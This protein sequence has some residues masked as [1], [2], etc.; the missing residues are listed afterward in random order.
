MA[1]NSPQSLTYCAR[2]EEK[3]ALPMLPHSLTRPGFVRD[4]MA[5][6]P[7]AQESH[8]YQLLQEYFHF[9]EK[10]MFFNVARLGFLKYLR[11]NTFLDTNRIKILAPLNGATSEW[12]NDIGIDS[13]R[14]Y[15]TPIVNLFSALTDPIPLTEK[16]V[17]YH[18]SQNA[19]KDRT[20]EVY[21]IEQVFA[22]SGQSSEPQEVPPYFSFK[23]S[24][25]PG[26][27]T[28]FLW[29]S[30]NTPTHHKNIYG[31]DTEISFVDADFNIADTSEYIIYTK[32]MCSNRFLAEDILQNTKLQIEMALPVTGITCLKA[33]VTPEYSLKKG[34]NNAKLIAQLSINYLGFPYHHTGDIAE[35]I[36]KIL[37]MHASDQAQPLVSS[38]L[39]EMLAMQVS[40]TT[41][42]V[43]REAWRG[44]VDGVHVQIS[45]KKTNSVESWFLLAVVLQRYFAMNCQINTFVE[46]SLVVDGV[47]AFRLDAV[48]GEQMFI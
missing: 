5:I 4:E 42:R 37:A 38:M 18:V 27:S 28:K 16:R 14:L 31:I 3:V 35:N 10:F 8:A 6:T 47:E 7:K 40:H 23:S 32:A 44:I 21:D 19:Y 36:R 2:G 1:L 12:A 33:P 30:K 13:L 15:C 24:Q 48:S 17:F 43:G 22:L 46:L 34:R 26:N 41:K 20:T 11:E 39:Q 25:N 45:L 29:W 9:P